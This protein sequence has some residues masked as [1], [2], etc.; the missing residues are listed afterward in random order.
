MVL[1]PSPNQFTSLSRLVPVDQLRSIRLEERVVRSPVRVHF[2]DK[3]FDLLTNRRGVSQ[4]DATDLQRP[5]RFNNLERITLRAT[6]AVPNKLLPWGEDPFLRR[7]RL[8]AL[9]FAL[10]RLRP[11]VG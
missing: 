9:R 4:L 6:L 3:H 1:H 10:P 5:A 11:L 7:I 2:T 8:V